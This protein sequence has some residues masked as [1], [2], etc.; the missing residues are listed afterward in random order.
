MKKIPV[1]S[2]ANHKKLEVYMGNGTT[3]LD[4]YGECGDEEKFEFLYDHFSNMR[5]LLRDYRET[6]IEDI[7]DLKIYKRRSNN[8]DLGVRVQTSKGVS[9]PVEN[10][11]VAR[12]EIARAIDARYLDEEYFHAID[13]QWG[14]MKQILSYRSATRDY[15][16]FRSKFMCLKVRDR[17]IMKPYME[18]EK[19]MS[20]VAEDYNS[21]YFAMAKRISRIKNKLWKMMELEFGKR[22]DGYESTKGRFR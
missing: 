22:V 16:K 8:G 21:D 4:G 18:Q 13:I 14:L 15:N 12:D 11:V 9:R 10:E 1:N 7:L 19:N 3:N 6:L 5:E 2:S 17:R 20:E